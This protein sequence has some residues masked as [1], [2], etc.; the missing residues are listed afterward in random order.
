MAYTYR[1]DPSVPAF[2]DDK[3]IVL[4]DG[5][6]V[7]CSRSARF[8]MWADRR[9]R[10][11][12]LA[13]QTPL[14]AALYRHFRLEPAAYETMILLEN[15][16]PRFRSDAGLRIAALLGLPW[17]MASLARIV[18][19]PWRDGLYSVVARN[20]IRWFGARTSCFRPDPADADRFIG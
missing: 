7:F 16:V 20:R 8:I 12:L 9:R 4:F 13:A 18:P 2:A 11:R 14:G 6:C 10:L 5:E 19:R 1:T 3:P 15:G 17:S